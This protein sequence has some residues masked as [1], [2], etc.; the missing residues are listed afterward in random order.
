MAIAHGT[1]RATARGKSYGAAATKRRFDASLLDY[2]RIVDGLI[3]HRI[4]QTD[5]LGDR[6]R[7]RRREPTGPA[8]CPFGD[9]PF[10]NLE[11]E[12]KP[13][14][15]YVLKFGGDAMT[16]GSLPEEDAERAIASAACWWREHRASGRIVAGA[17]LMPP[18]SAT[19][20]RFSEGRAMVI[21]GPF[22]S[23]RDAIGGFGLIDV[24]D[25]DEALTLA[26]GWP[27]DGYVEIR[28]LMSPT[29]RTY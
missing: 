1:A 9:L 12:A 8:R 21:D 20:V 16:A 29:G 24:R 23:E 13:E 7:A 27:L 18:Y 10:V 25:L 5:V 28:P 22:N 26:R 15:L 19:T 2:V 17:K 6:G 4:Q 3:V 14:V 11:D